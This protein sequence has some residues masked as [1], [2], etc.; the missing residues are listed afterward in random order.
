MNSAQKTLLY[1]LVALI[2][3]AYF[4]F[5]GLVDAKG[6]LAPLV[7][8]I[9]LALLLIP[10]ANLMEGKLN[11]LFS[12]LLSTVLL[13]LFSFGVFILLSFQIKNFVDDW[14]KIKETMTPKIEQLQSY[15]YEHTAL[16]SEDLE[17]Y[18]K[19]NDIK[20]M[21]TSGGNS[22]QQAFNFLNSVTSFLSNYLLTFIYIF[23]LLNYR[24]RF[25]IFILKLFSNQ[26]KKQVKQIIDETARVAQFYLRGKLILIIILSILY[27]IGLGI[28]G[29]NNYILIAVIASF[30]TLIPFIGNIIGMG[31]A[32][33]FGYLT[34]GE[35]SILIGVILTFTLVQFIESYVLEP[36]IVGDKVDI[37][38]FFVI[39]AIILGNMIWGVMGMIL[40]IPV[41]GILNVVFNHVP[42]LEPF[43]YLLSTDEEKD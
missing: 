17:E 5:T 1:P 38:P 3:G 24:R 9:I 29:V 37:H 13:L 35:T 28:S 42:A 11:R 33:I 23:F 39:L 36:F 31:L 14:D 34:Q 7:T 12:S 43:G 25:K 20:S 32:L 2:V 4:L 8:A 18:K 19:E 27:S 16:S 21:L 40:A 6:F 10:L 26:R 22:G 15:A 41:L 30:L